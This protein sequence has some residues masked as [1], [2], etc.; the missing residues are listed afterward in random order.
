MSPMKSESSLLENSLFLGGGQS[1]CSIQVFNRISDW[2][3]P[4]YTVEGNLLCS[5]SAD[6]IV[7]FTQNTVTETSE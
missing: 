6:L 2:M 7:N 3:R 1:F 4:T 5:H